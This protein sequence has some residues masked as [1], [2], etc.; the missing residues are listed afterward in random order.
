MIHAA[1]HLWDRWEVRGKKCAPGLLIIYRLK[2]DT[3]RDH[4]RARDSRPGI[5]LLEPM[6]NVR[7]G[8]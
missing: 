6:L 3:G 4:P 8:R 7:V 1:G 2:F 5:D